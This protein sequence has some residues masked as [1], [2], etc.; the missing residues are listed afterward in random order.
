M[1]IKLNTGTLFTLKM[2][3]KIRLVLV[4]YDQLVQVEQSLAPIIGDAGG[5]QK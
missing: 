4:F 3:M 2:L 1:P 5:S